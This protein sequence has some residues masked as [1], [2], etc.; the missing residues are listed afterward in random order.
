MRLTVWQ[1]RGPLQPTE[2]AST[3]SGGTG[4]IRLWA[5]GPTTG[6]VEQQ[7]SPAPR[8]VHQLLIVYFL[9]A[10]WRLTFANLSPQGH[11]GSEDGSHFQPSSPSS[12]TPRTLPAPTPPLS[13]ALTS[14]LHV[15]LL[16]GSLLGG[17]S[18]L[19]SSPHW[20]LPALSAGV[21]GISQDL[22]QAAPSHPLCRRLSHRVRVERGLSR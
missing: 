4:S 21:L 14:A 12:Q 2:P 15:Q 3:C 13:A 20:L 9:P 16:P 6:R 11:L 1:P 18:H 5:R 22:A 17:H 10:G 19:E 7:G 8:A